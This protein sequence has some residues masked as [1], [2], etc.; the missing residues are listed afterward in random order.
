LLAIT[1]LLGCS[2]SGA[3]SVPV[4]AGSEVAIESDASSIDAIFPTDDATAEKPFEDF[5]LGPYPSARDILIRGIRASA[6]SLDTSKNYSQSAAQGYTLQAI[7]TFLSATKGRFLPEREELIGLAFGEI[8]ELMDAA[9]QTED[10]EPGYGLADAWDAFDDGSTNPAYTCY[11][12]QTGMVA[13]GMVTF[14]GYLEE[15]GGHDEA[16]AKIRAFVTKLLAPWAKRWTSITEGGESLGWYWYSSQKADAKATHNTS[17]LISMAVH[18]LDP[19]DPKPGRYAQ[20][21]R[22]RWTTTTAGGYAWNYVDDG[23]PAS[24]RN[25][26]DISHSLLTTQFIRFARD[27][28]WFT[29]ADMSH[30]ANTFLSQIWSG[31]PARMHGRVDGSSG[32]TDEWSWSAAA[33]VGMAAHAD[34]PGGRP[35]LFDYT[36]SVLV[37]SYLTGQ[38]LATASADSVRALAIALLFAHRPK[39]WAPDSLWSRAAGPGDDAASGKSGGVRFYKSDWSAPKKLSA[40]GLDLTAR[41]ATATNANLVVDLPEDDAR[42][43]VVSITYQS[44]AAG[45]VQQWDGTRFSTIAELPET[46]NASGKNV[47]MRTSFLLNSTRFDYQ[48][49]EGVNVLLQLTPLASVAKI[50]ATPL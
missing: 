24:M 19:K 23:Y 39:A 37:S 43:V 49:G 13:I 16:R 32:G 28:D 9:N 18:L 20:L 50:E 42:R 6:K 27:N 21:L 30:T 48:S 5:S 8:D 40:S 3:G 47:W 46:K 7:G 17:A 44:D 2:S 29:N 11:A 34:A 41:T 38:P 1:L 4:D 22:R 10:G 31:N 15:A 33:T 36:R 14:L 35:E 12:W 25:A 26:E 45:L